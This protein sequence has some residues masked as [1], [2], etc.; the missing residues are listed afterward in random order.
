MS[1]ELLSTNTS[2]FLSALIT[3][4]HWDKVELQEEI[5]KV[6][7]Q[8]RENA[9]S[10]EEYLEAL[11]VNVT[12]Q[13]ANTNTAISFLAQ[14]I[15]EEQFFS[16]ESFQ[17][18]MVNVPRQFQDSNFLAE[19]MPKFKELVYKGS[20]IEEQVLH[21]EMFFFHTKLVNDL[22][23]EFTGAFL[24]PNNRDFMVNFLEYSSQVVIDTVMQN[25]QT[26]SNL[27][28]EELNSVTSTQ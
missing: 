18:I 24:H 6:L 25:C 14:C 8:I 28:I 20:S 19:N 17:S 27:I 9:S 21:A 2:G 3:Q 26:Y 12:F 11:L 7:L 5:Q 15:E 22:M 23:V 4:P 10:Q 16:Q 13:Y 1:I